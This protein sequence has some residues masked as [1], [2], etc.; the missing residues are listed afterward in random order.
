MTS[1]WD[2]ELLD[3]LCAAPGIPG[4]EGPAA[5][6]VRAQLEAWGIEYTSDGI[7]NLTAHIPGKGPKVALVAHLDEVGLIVRKIHPGG[8][9]YV[10]RLGGTSVHVLPGQHVDVWVDGRPIR[11]VVGALPQHLNPGGQSVSL[12]TLYIDVGVGSAQAAIEMGLQVGTPV[13]YVPALVCLENKVVS[14]ALDDRLGCHLL[15]RLAKA[16]IDVPPESD[17]Y[18]VFTVQEETLQRAA[19]PVIRQIQPDY[20]V[21]VDGTLAFDTPD[22]ADGQNDIYLGGGTAIK[23]MDAIRGQGMGL[24]AHPPLRKHLE[25]L[26]EEARIPFQR[27]VLTGLTTAVTPLPYLFNGLPVAALSFPMRYAHS[28]VEM[29]DLD[30]VENTYRL[31][32]K[33][34]RIPWHPGR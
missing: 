17:L 8:Y 11:G 34:V 14:K 12:E 27:E 9:L 3:R 30:D 20:V 4:F 13:T 21:G 1:L 5:D 10:E 31:L 18:L 26:A 15:L 25:R 28:P 6:V 16:V 22:L 2:F 33:L 19:D 24:V 7:D 23:V 29:A 32:E